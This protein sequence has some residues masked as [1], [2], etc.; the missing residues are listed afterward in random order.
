METWDIFILYDLKSLLSPMFQLLFQILLWLGVRALLHS[1][2]SICP[3]L[4][5]K[6]GVGALLQLWVGVRVKSLLLVSTD[7]IMGFPC[8]QWVRRKFPTLHQAF[9]D[10]TPVKKKGTPCYCQ[11]ELEV[12]THPLVPIG[13]VGERASYC[14]V[15]RK[16]L[17]PSCLS[18]SGAGCRVLHYDLAKVEVQSPHFTF[19]GVDGGG[20]TVFS[21]VFELDQ[22]SYCLKV[23]YIA[24]FLLSWSFDQYKQGFFVLFCLCLFV[25]L[26][27]HRLQFQV[28]DK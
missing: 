23:F 18:A 2:F 8:Y 11:V 14:L 16:V 24:R 12:L 28:W 9:S 17:A 22:S 27:C 19:S 5:P 25:F 20:A 26:G 21:G 7:T 10:A 4:T 13:A 1:S 6:A 3:P 15:M